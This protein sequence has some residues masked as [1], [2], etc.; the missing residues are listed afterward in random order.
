MVITTNRS[1]LMSTSNDFA[2]GKAR[3]VSSD[4][5]VV[6]FE[7]VEI[8]GKKD[9]KEYNRK[10]VFIL[11]Y[12]H[13]LFTCDLSVKIRMP[14]QLEISEFTL[15]SRDGLDFFPYRIDFKNGTDKYCNIWIVLS[16]DE[17]GELS[18]FARSK[19]KEVRIDSWP[20]PKELIDSTVC[21]PYIVWE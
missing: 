17:N 4:G 5:N 11:S 8:C 9:C 16:E 14:E 7:D 10:E 3:I 2:K 15:P 18:V 19:I 6:T 20:L 12:L 13:W 1:N 21:S